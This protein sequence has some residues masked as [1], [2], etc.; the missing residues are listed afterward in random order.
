M[1]RRT[2]IRQLIAGSGSLFVSTQLGILACESEDSMASVDEMELIGKQAPELYGDDYNLRKT[3]SE[4]FSD[5]RS[6]AAREGVR[7]YSVSSYRSFDHQR[8]IWNRKFENLTDRGVDREKA[9][10]RII[11]YSAIPGTSRHHW[12]TEVDVIDAS[13]PQEG[14]VLQAKH[15][16]E[17]G[18]FETLGK[19]LKQNAVSYGF[20]ETY[21]DDPARTGFEY[22]PWHLSFAELSIPILAEY[23]A[24]PLEK[25]LVDETIKGSHCFSDEFLLMYRNN[26]V[27]GI[28]PRLLPSNTAPPGSTG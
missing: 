2:F 25:H 3:A 19:W 22:E 15:F 5:M 18:V 23:L 26:Y 6:D 1:R 10:E 20:Y 17:G 7:L 4:A 24:I 8:R 13:K 28:E 16:G 14:D 9:V 12:G 21:T 27:L 11:R